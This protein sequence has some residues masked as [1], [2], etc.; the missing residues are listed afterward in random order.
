MAQMI[1]SSDSV[2]L[3]PEL[4]FLLPSSMHSLCNLLLSVLSLGSLRLFPFRILLA[5]ARRDSRTVFLFDAF[6]GCP[7]LTCHQLRLWVPFLLTLHSSKVDS[8]SLSHRM[9]GFLAPFSEKTLTFFSFLLRF[10]LSWFSQNLLLGRTPTE[11]PSMRYKHLLLNLT[12]F[13]QFNKK[14]FH[15][16]LNRYVQHDRS[17]P[18]TKLVPFKVVE[19]IVLSASM[20]CLLGDGSKDKRKCEV[21]GGKHT[22]NIYL[23]KCKHGCCFPCLGWSGEGCLGF[24]EHLRLCSLSSWQRERHLDS[25]YLFS[26]ACSYS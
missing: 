13:A 23:K 17:I 24:P 10:V 12:S 16:I 22:L 14:G 11:A 1:S 7:V 15:T 25:G 4:R 5:N 6:S 21:N 8:C 18:Q 26:F 3:R 9:L 20:A 2:I 19:I